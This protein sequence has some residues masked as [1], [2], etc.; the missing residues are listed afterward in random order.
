M[1]KTTNNVI[2]FHTLETA[3]EMSIR[4]MNATIA[5]PDKSERTKL[6]SKMILAIHHNDMLE[7]DRIV[8][9]LERLNNTGITIVK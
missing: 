7:F 1:K 6:E 4:N 2:E 8:A 9:I 3:T 5:N